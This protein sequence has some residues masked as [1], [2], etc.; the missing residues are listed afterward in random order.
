MSEHR[1]RGDVRNGLKRILLAVTGAGIDEYVGRL[2]K[3][4][5]R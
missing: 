4:E 3:D 2:V 1:G 5:D